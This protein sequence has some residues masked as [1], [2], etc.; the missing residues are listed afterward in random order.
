MSVAI[1]I[2]VYIQ[3]E[4]LSLIYKTLQH[5][6]IFTLS[7]LDTLVNW[8]MFTILSYLTALNNSKY[9]S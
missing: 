5:H 9:P 8:M 2:F 4:L 6:E 7:L 1:N 3:I